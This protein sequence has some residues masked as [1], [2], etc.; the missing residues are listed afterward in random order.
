MN[1]CEKLFKLRSEAGL[2]QEKFSEIVGVSR[3]AVQKWENGV[4]LPDLE[5][6]AKIA[7]YFRVSLDALLLGRDQRI[8]EELFRE[9]K[10]EYSD[11]HQWDVYPYAEYLNVEYRQCVEEG[12]DVA[13]WE[14]L[15]KAVEKMPIDENQKKAADVIFDIVCHAK[16]QENYGYE[17][18]SDLAGIQ[19]LTKPYLLTA[20]NLT[21]EQLRDKVAGAWYGRI[22]G[23]LLGKPIEGIRTDELIPLLKETGNYPMHRYIMASDIT[24]DIAE[25]YQFQLKGKCYPDAIQMAPVDDD[26]NYTVLY[27]QLVK[28]YGRGFTPLDVSKIWTDLQSKNAYCTAERVAYHN[29]MKGYLPPVSAV[30]KNPFREWIGA[31]IRADYFGYINPGD[32][33]QAADMAWRDASVSHIKNGIYGEMMV[34]AMLACAAVTD[35]LEEVLQG[36][37][38][39]IPATSRLYEKMMQVITDYKNGVSQTEAFKKIHQE[40]DEFDGHDWCHTISNAMIVV[41]ALLYGGL[42]YGKSI[43][44][45]VETGFDTDCNGATVGS[46]IGMMKGKSAM[47]SYWSDP[48]HGMQATTI[49]GVENVSIDQLVDVT[50]NHIDLK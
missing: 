30:Y 14:E 3:Q 42:D 36:G 50:L 16:P 39:Q 29:F 10:P 8:A 49:F 48:V 4:A 18:P 38:A 11:P 23:C 26:T 32:P 6:A 31:Q 46:I 5:N 12:L 7:K 20:K 41:A 34:A 33:C 43:C 17:E 40:Y 13:A 24:E 25:R 47:P 44:M 9:V 37:L 19:S 28:Q 15:F 27:Q 22:C 45:A 35:D 1:F 2:S 21:P